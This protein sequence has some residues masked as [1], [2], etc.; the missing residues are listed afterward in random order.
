[1]HTPS[2]KNHGVCLSSGL[3]KSP[4]SSQKATPDICPP[5]E[6]LEAWCKQSSYHPHPVFWGR[7]T[8]NFNIK[9]GR[10]F[11]KHSL[12]SLLRPI[13]EAY[14]QCLNKGEHVIWDLVQVYFVHFPHIKVY[15]YLIIYNYCLLLHALEGKSSR[16]NI[17]KG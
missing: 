11:G 17:Q 5:S 15:T 16:Y 6:E 3:S 1:M 2:H 4:G 13:N 12:H 7:H 9:K 8:F 14:F 10:P